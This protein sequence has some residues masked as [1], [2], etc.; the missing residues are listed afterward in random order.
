MEQQKNTSDSEVSGCVLVVDDD[1]TMRTIH[2]AFL[3]KQFDVVTVA[4]GKE[5][6]KI[7]QEWLPDLILLD[8]EMPELGGYETCRQLR[9]LTARPIIFATAHQSLEEHLKAYDAGGN[10]LI[11]KPVNSEILLRKVALAIR[12]HQATAKIAHEK[13]SL[14]QMAMSF[15]SSMGESGTLLNFMRASVGSRSHHTLAENLVE[16]TKNF[17]V[18]CSVLIRHENGPT[19]LNAA[20]ETSPLEL[21]I[22]EQSADMGRIFQFGHRLVVNYDRVSIIVADMPSET[23]FPEEAG[24]IR[25][26][27]VILA[28]TAEALCDNVDMR[29]ESTLRAEQLQVAL[30][31]AEE[32][33]GNLRQKYLDMLGDTRLLLQAL[34]DEVERTYAWLE[35]NQS[36]ETAISETMDRSVQRILALL[37][38]GGDFDEQFDLVLAALRGSSGGGKAI[39]LF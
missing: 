27:L 4:S 7:C 29:L 24:R 36:Q 16:A 30:S 39:E 32:A 28:E 22:L 17:N 19:A 25:D 3:A 1:P 23:D 12:Q 13:D 21:A 15:L 38:A 35:T 9:A 33:L 5:A 34:V 6:L 11:T 10:D 37:A 2:R 18:R 14:Q 8:V 26:N 20:G 31:S